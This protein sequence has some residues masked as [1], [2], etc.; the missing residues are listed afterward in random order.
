MYSTQD[1]QIHT[2][3]CINVMLRVRKCDDPF[4]IRRELT[5]CMTVLT[6][7]AISSCAFHPGATVRCV[8]HTREPLDLDHPRPT[9]HHATHRDSSS[10]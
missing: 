5:I 10:R 1:T 7:G 9:T 3:L 8:T 2:T 6:L 4:L